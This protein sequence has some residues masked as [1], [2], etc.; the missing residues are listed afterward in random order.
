MSETTFVSLRLDAQLVREIDALANLEG[1][2]RTAVIERAAWR[3]VRSLRVTGRHS[4]FV[5]NLGKM[6]LGTPHEGD[7]ACEMTFG[8]AALAPKRRRS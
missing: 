4:W 6:P 7:P 1:L 8:P 5:E 2:T 3:E